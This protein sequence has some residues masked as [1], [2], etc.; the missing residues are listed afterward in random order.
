MRRLI[1]QTFP[2]HGIVGEEYGQDRPD[3][4]YVW[5]LDPIDGTKS[6]ISGLPMWGTLIG[7]MHRGRPVYGMMSQPFTRERYFGDGKRARWRGLSAPRGDR[8]DGE[9]ANRALHVRAC[10]SLAEATLMT[11]SP[12]LF[13]DEDRA[14]YHRVEKPARLWHDVATLHPRALFGRRQARAV[15]RAGA[16][17]RRFGGRRMDQPHLACAPLRRARRG[18]LDDNQPVA[19]Q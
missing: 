13:N 17:A 12:L 18:D 7:L 9:W 6:F 14:A 10:S 8:P 11:T 16:A 4:E 15:A 2:A 1:G 3:A 5:V 19:V